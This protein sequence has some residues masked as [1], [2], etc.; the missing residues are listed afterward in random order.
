[1]TT[2]PVRS[3]P[4]FSCPVMPGRRNSST[5]EAVP[6]APVITGCWARRGL[7]CLGWF[8]VA[9]GVIGLVVPGLPTTVFLIVALWAFSR[10]SERFQLWLWNH[11]RLGPPLRRWHSHRVIPVGAKVSAIGMMGVS[12][13]VLAVFVAESWVLPVVVGGL[14]APAAVYILT[15]KSTVPST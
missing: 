4:R 3:K 10:S 1:M 5:E 7:L 9:L 8:L 13:F 2:E 15:R 11:P 12:L 14:M 6:V